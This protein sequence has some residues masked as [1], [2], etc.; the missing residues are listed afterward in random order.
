MTTT[1]TY[2]L[3]ELGVPEDVYKLVRLLLLDAEYQHA[4]DDKEGRLDMT[5]IALTPS[6]VQTHKPLESEELRKLGSGLIT[7]AGAMETPHLD[8]AVLRDLLDGREGTL[9]AR[10]AATQA[11]LQRER[12]EVV[13]MFDS[14]KV[15]EEH[16]QGLQ[17]LLEMAD[18]ESRLSGYD[19]E[20][21]S[22]AEA[23]RL[24]RVQRNEFVSSLRALLRRVEGF[25]GVQPP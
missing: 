13:R 20:E 22:P 8:L 9:R 1:Q 23:I 3:A 11:E 10:L 14:K 19:P 21:T 16:S 15:A 6:P 17:G 24:L 5:H 18:D 4:V 25:M 12:A 2:T 7:F